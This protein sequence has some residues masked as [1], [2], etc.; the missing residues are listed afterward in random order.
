MRPDCRCLVC[1]DYGDRDQLDDIDTNLVGHLDDPGWGVLAI[2]ADDISA[3]WA[4]TVGL[5]HS[6]RSPEIAVFGLSVETSIA[7]LNVIGERVAAGLALA[8]GDQLPETLKGDYLVTLKPVDPSWHEDFFGTASGFYRATPE[9][10]FLQVTWPDREGR[11][12]DEQEFAQ[13]IAHLQ[14]HLWLPR[15][16]HPVGPWRE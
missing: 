9:V 5:W 3:G 16:E 4:F 13:G 11:F 6:Y 8:P 15:D 1:H 14:P 2:P 7:H 10:P 12:P